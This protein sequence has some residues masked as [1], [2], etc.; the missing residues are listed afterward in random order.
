MEF[1]AVWKAE[2]L[3]LHVEMVERMELEGMK[4]EDVSRPVALPSE[5][6]LHFGYS[7][8]SKI[9]RQSNDMHGYSCTHTIQR[10]FF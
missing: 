1:I 7:A 9:S 5:G 3:R 4:M 6:V 10:V 2:L 8:K